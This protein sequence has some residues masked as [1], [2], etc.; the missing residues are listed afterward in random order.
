M[1]DIQVYI[2]YIIKNYEALSED[3]S[4]H[5]YINNINNRL[6]VKTKDGCKL[7]LQAPETMKLI[8]STKKLID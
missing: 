2:D 8:G 1:S 4:I 7:E 6:M 3:P 5:I